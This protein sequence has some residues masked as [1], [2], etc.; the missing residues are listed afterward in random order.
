MPKITTKATLVENRTEALILQYLAKYIDLC[1]VIDGGNQRV[2]CQSE[3]ATTAINKL[4]ICDLVWLIACPRTLIVVY[5]HLDV[6]SQ[7]QAERGSAGQP[8]FRVRIQAD[9]LVCCRCC[10]AGSLLCRPCHVQVADVIW[11]CQ[12]KRRRLE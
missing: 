10:P 7:L 11:I 3:L 9:H 12:M 2:R 1:C 5:N 4:M 8:H 6:P